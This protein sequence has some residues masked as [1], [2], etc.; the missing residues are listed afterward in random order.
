MKKKAIPLAVIVFL[1][2]LFAFA[3]MNNN[4]TQETI[5]PG[6]RNGVAI[7]MTGAAARIPQEAALLEELDRRGLLKNLVFISGVSSGALNSIMLNGILSGKM[8][9]DDYKDILYNLKNSDVF[10]QEGKKFP[11]NTSPARELYKRLIE[12]K[13]GYF[14]I[15]DLPFNT[16]ISFTHLKDMDLKK[17][18]YR[19][20]SR[21]INE[22]TD[23]TLNLVD[24]IMA[25][26]A[27]PIVFPSVRISNVK[28]IP[29]IEYVDGGIGDDHVPYHALL[30]FEKFRGA[31]VE[32]VYIISRKSDS[33]PEISEELKG[34]GINDNGLFDRLGIS[35]DA[36]LNKGIVKRLEAYAAEAPELVPLT[37]IW[38]PDYE[39]DF[40][41]FNFDDLKAQYILTAQWAKTHDPL[42]LGDYLLPYLLKKDIK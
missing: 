14:R 40:L 19:M 27:F 34:L 22:E 31:G 9:W 16:G 42:P 12:D 38:I 7:I 21:K 35:L 25:S 3:K 37:Y 13:L 33:V 23:T 36:I 24:I 17:T 20:C 29:D 28:T 11:V 26:S 18:V 5:V 41:L 8:T 39:A 1:S 32:K 15:G 10:V 2:L 6:A 30:E 4:T